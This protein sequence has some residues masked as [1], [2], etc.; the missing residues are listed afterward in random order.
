MNEPAELRPIMV[1]GPN[2]SQGSRFAIF[3]VNIAVAFH[4]TIVHGLEKKQDV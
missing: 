1:F 4:L 2:N 3:T